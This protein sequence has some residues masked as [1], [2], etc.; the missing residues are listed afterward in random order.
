MTVAY[1]TDRSQIWI[2]KDE[3]IE[4]VVLLQKKKIFLKSVNG[5]STYKIRYF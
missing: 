1:E 5:I 3:T 2:L 4:K